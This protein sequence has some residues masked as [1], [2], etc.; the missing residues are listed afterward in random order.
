MFKKALGLLATFAFAF[1]FA[2]F[3]LPQKTNIA[4]SLTGEH[5]SILD[6]H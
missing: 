2:F 3:G 5:T 6:C 1:A 4:E